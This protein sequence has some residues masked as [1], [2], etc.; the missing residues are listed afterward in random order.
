V[1]LMKCFVADRDVTADLPV[2][3]QDM[4]SMPLPS[5]TRDKLQEIFHDIPNAEITEASLTITVTP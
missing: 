2:Y 3:L 4:T 5:E 1:D